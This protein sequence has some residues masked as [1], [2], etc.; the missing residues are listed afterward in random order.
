MQGPLKGS[1]L[2]RQWARVLTEVGRN[3]G[4]EWQWWPDER[5]NLE[6]KERNKRSG[7][8]F[9]INENNTVVNVERLMF[10]IQQIIS[11]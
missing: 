5:I 2:R 1:W 8:C 11:R 6:F 4:T 10:C 3:I 9:Q 7:F